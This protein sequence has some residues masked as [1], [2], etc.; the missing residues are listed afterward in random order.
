MGKTI[1]TP[2]QHKLLE[3]AANSSVV[4]DSFYFTGGTALAEKLGRTIIS[5]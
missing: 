3:C 2:N 5:R 1:L 4:L